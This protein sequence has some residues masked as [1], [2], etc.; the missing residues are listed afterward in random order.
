[1]QA[2]LLLLSFCT[3]LAAKAAPGEPPL[4]L[5][6]GPLPL[7]GGSV[8]SDVGFAVA[9]DAEVGLAN[10]CACA[11]AERA[12]RE[13]L[14]SCL[15]ATLLLPLLS[16]LKSKGGLLEEPARRK[17]NVI[18]SLAGYAAVHFQKRI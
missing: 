16:N 1:M 7:R 6:D 4:A 14:F 9:K 3:T 5:T 18:T 11:P 12:D 13:G 2:M 17:P 15:T 8:S 10:G